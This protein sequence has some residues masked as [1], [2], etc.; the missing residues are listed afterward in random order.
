MSNFDG[1]L[2]QTELPCLLDDCAWVGKHLTLHMH[3]THN[4]RACDFKRA[5][6][7]NLGTGVI[8]KP[9]AVALQGREMQGVAASPVYRPEM[10]QAK[11]RTGYVSAE[12][13]EHRLKVRL[14]TEG[15]SGPCRVCAGC[16]REFMQSTRFG[17]AK[18]CTIPCRSLHANYGGT[19]WKA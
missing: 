13:G 5:S 17:R 11:K 12:S 3:H 10:Q 18:Y 1:F 14:L 9:L 6:G 2:E 16:G 19:K 15:V 4:I 8:C 7:F